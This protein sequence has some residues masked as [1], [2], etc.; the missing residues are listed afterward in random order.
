[1]PQRAVGQSR[2]G[3]WGSCEWGQPEGQKAQAII[4][5]VLLSLD[6]KI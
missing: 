5:F 2:F 3:R 6:F 4:S 1:M